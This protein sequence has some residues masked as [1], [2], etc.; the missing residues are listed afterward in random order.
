M[1]VV[2][3]LAFFLFFLVLLGACFDP[4]EFPEV[5]QISLNKVRFGDDPDEGNPDSVVISLNFR[6]GDGDLGLDPQNPRHS[7]FPFQ[8][9][10]FFQTDGSGGLT[11]VE[12]SSLV[13]VDQSNNTQT[14]VDYIDVPDPDKGTLAYF[15]SRRT[16]TYSNLPSYSCSDYVFR[17]FIVPVADAAILGP[18][19]TVIDTIEGEYIYVK[20]SLYHRS[21]PNHYNIEVDFLIK[22]GNTFDTLDFRQA[23]CSTFDGRFPVLSD[24][25]NPLE[26]TLDYSL[27]S[28]FMKLFLED[29]TF[30][31]RIRIRDRAL[32]VSNTIITDNLTLD[33]I[34]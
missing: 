20:D 21:N 32:H 25:D 17:E 26:G 1:K 29:Q 22:V 15:S 24:D 6:D 3:G 12:I 18:T 16:S 14:V 4:P 2:K 5:P 31:F 23:N 27:N 13:I 7:M 9:A 30:K 19:V 11:P 34:R 8:F 33:E 10:D 28:L